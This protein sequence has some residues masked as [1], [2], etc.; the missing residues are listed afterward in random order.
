M[1]QIL[2][3]VREI[4]VMERVQ[5]G[6][7]GRESEDY[8]KSSGFAEAVSGNKA[9][10][11]P[12]RHNAKP[13]PFKLFSLAFR[14]FPM[15]PVIAIVGQPNVGKSTLF[16]SL[17]RTRNALV[18]DMPGLTRD[19]Q[20]GLGQR[21]SQPY[22]VVDTGGLTGEEEGMDGWWRGRS[23]ELLMKPMRCCCWWMAAPA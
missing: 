13:V 23:G 14:R 6:R 10:Q 3:R 4:G 7:D 12:N 2:T 17:T 20:Y 18:A 9:E 15:L 8:Q 1:P 22:M 21:G 11:R 19:R 5:G 16:N